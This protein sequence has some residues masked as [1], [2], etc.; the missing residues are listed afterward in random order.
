ME[1][2]NNKYMKKKA[3]YDYFHSQKWRKFQMVMKLKLVLLFCCTGSIVASPIFSQQT[4]LTV[5]YE[6]TEIV[7]I[8][9]DLRAKTGYE[10]FYQ[11]DIFPQGLKAT[12]SMHEATLEEVLDQVLGGNGYTYQIKND[13][14]IIGPARTPAVQQPA[15]PVVITG[16]VLDS[17]GAPVIGA[18][19][20]IKN[21]QVGAVTDGS[22]KFTVRAPGSTGVVLVISF[23]GKTQVEVTYTGQQNIVVTLEDDV[24]AIE[25]VVVTGFFERK[26]ESFTGSASTFTG[27]QLKNVS[28]QNVF[29]ALRSLDPS[30]SI[31]TNDQYGSDPNRLPDIDIRGKTSIVDPRQ[32]YTTDP[33]QPLYIMDGFEVTPQDVKNLNVNRIATLTI[34]KD[35][36]STAIYGAKAANG[37]IVIETIK[38]VVGR[39][40]VTYA[41][42]FDATFADLSDYN[43]MNSSEKLKAEVAAG[44]YKENDVMG[45]YDRMEMYNDRL[46][47]V[48]S[49]VDTYW[50]KVPLRT[51]FANRHDIYASG[52][53]QYMTYGLG[54]NYANT[55]GA[56]KKSGNENL[57]LTVDLSYRTKNDKFRFQNKFTLNHYSTWKPPVS[58]STYAETNPYLEKVDGSDQP[59]WLEEY[60]T[61]Y[62]VDSYYTW[63]ASNPLYNETLNHLNDSKDIN[64][65]NNFYIDWRPVDGLLVAGRFSVSAARENTEYFKSPYHTDY[66]D[67]SILERGEYTKTST[68]INNYSGDIRAIYN[69]TLN[70]KH[71]LFLNATMQFE[72]QKTIFDGYSAIGFS[73]DIIPY[74]SFA[75]QY[76]ENATPQYNQVIMRS[77]NFFV[78]TGYTY[79]NRYSVDFTVRRDGSSNFGSDNLFTTSWSAGL[80]WNLHREE[81]FAGKLELFKLRLTIG[82]VGNSGTNYATTTTY[83]YN[84]QS[85]LYGSGVYISQFGSYG[86]AWEKTLDMNVGLDFTTNKRRFSATVDL[87]QKIT[88]PLIISYDVAASTGRS[89]LLRNMGRN[90]IKGVTFSANFNVINRPEDGFIWG[91]GVTGSAKKSKFSKMGDLDQLNEELRE[92]GYLLR[93]YDGGS[94]Y[95]IW[96]TQSAGID[97]AT[98]D[99]IYVKP[100][101]TY[102]FTWD[103]SYERVVGN[104]QPDLEGRINS[105]FRYKGWTAGI[106]LHYIIGQDQINR[107]LMERIEGLNTSSMMGKNQDKRALYDRWQKVGDQAKYKRIT[108][109]SYASTHETTRFLQTKNWLA[110]ESLSVG[111]SFDNQPWLRKAGMENITVSAIVNDIFNWSTILQERGILY[112]YAR[113]VSLSVNITF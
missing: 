85:N 31:V 97:P 49:G 46:E 72:S 93:Y 67:T 34:L 113:T 36:A 70:R 69:K 42:S 95:S 78:Q 48:L 17:N 37:V 92:A 14:V 51:G 4:S 103:K 22:G 28:T 107:A 50:L 58:F 32:N 15:A 100:D 82:K 56:M 1:N 110:G 6:N 90:T 38:P 80:A 47:R 77:A 21:T 24:A 16:T 81:F 68:N 76:P 41:G 75:S 12:V 108:D 84:T 43:M 30:L 10:F 104:S 101:G 19:V 23:L 7:K 35:A 111:Y 74:P 5:L 2:F 29:Q 99:E 112:P 89:G 45:Q 73:D 61:S 25:E 86:L 102:T 91:V 33:N 55:Q 96:A 52:G 40:R 87:Y 54:L 98:G 57:G 11:K 94:Q 3:Y 106:Y 59:R 88:D 65:R 53:D 18:T 62:D 13:H 66:E 27:T 71:N 109:L 39:L 105:T 8:I 9:D 83:R 26:A 79:D 60:R 44:I 20:I 64:F 63:R